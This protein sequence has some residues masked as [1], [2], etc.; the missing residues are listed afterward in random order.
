MY[1]EA[2]SLTTGISALQGG[3]LR[4][5]RLRGHGSGRV[6]TSIG[7]EEIEVFAGEI[8]RR[9]EAGETGPTTPEATDRRPTPP[10][11]TRT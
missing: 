2:L 7:R 9:A 3:R 11:T 6:T 4:Y 5:G 8:L 10:R 1:V